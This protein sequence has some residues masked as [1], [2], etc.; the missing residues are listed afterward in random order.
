MMKKLSISLVV[1]TMNRPTQ[2]EHL[3][4]TLERQTVRADQIFV[5]DQSRD[6]LTRDVVE[7]YATR[8]PLTYFH[9][10]ARGLSCARNVV[11]D[12]ISGDIV[13]FPDDDCWYPDDTIARAVAEF[14][15]DADL[16]VF[17]GAS[18]SE[19]GVP[20]QGRWGTERVVVD[21]RSVWTSQT[22]YTTYYRTSVFKPLGGFD[23]TLGV[24]GSTP[25]GAGE[26]TDL[27]LRALAT[28]AR[29]VYDPTFRVFHPEPLAVY[30]EGAYSRGR[31]YNRGVGRVLRLHRFP[32][33]FVGYMVARPA[34]G[35]GVAMLKGQ[36]PLAKY[37]TITAVNRLRGFMD[38]L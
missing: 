30:D 5:V 33:W 4:Q 34:V 1:A 31:K 23:E 21:K 13:A 3:F 29:A 32:P 12:L 37:R 15:K 19:A 36:L 25:W 24:G 22:S 9:R 14:E 26:E 8:L 18:M 6:D 38:P 11:H 28:G 35:I 7:R 16:G 2:L 27:L 20:S 10:E 17:T